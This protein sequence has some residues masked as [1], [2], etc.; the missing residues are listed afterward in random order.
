M[1]ALQSWNLGLDVDRVLAA[2]GADPAA[3][4]R[5]HP[6]LVTTAERALREGMALIVPR[7]ARRTLAVTG[8]DEHGLHLA[9]GG[10]LHGAYVEQ[11][12][13]DADAIAVAVCTIG[14]ALEER[15]SELL[16]DDGVLA[17]AFD[18]LGSA[19]ADALAGAVCGQVAEEAAAERSRTTV[20]L[21]PGMMGWPLADGQDALFSLVDAAGI[22]VALTPSRLMIPRK[23]VSMVIGIGPRVVAGGRTCD[24][25]NMKET[26]RYRAGAGAPRGREPGA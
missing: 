21:S 5:R 18:G 15:V 6:S 2:Q 3:I 8:R 1:T 22:G 4:R 13:S 14:A 24:V 9:G 26:C 23:S 20:P 16:E 7:T 11:Q 19:A 10:R 25:C 12:L 17:L